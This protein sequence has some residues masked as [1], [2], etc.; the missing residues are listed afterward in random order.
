MYLFR[1]SFN[2]FGQEQ[3]HFKGNEF[4]EEGGMLSC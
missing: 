4:R 2:I 3:Q 1:F